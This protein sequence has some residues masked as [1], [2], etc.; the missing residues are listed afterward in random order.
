MRIIS[1]KNPTITLGKKDAK[2]E[3][4]NEFYFGPLLDL[5]FHFHVSYALPADLKIFYSFNNILNSL[6]TLFRPLRVIMTLFRQKFE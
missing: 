3:T 6:L 2:K 5:K 1:N 4:V